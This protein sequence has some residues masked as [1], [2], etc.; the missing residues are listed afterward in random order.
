MKK[1]I[2]EIHCFDANGYYDMHFKRID[3]VMRSIGESKLLEKKW[4]RSTAI[5]GSWAL[6]LILKYE[7]TIPPLDVK[8]AMI[9]LEYLLKEDVADNEIFNGNTFFRIADIDVYDVSEKGS[10][11]RG[12][13]FRKGAKKRKLDKFEIF[14]TSRLDEIIRLGRDF[15]RERVSKDVLK[16]CKDIE[17]KIIN[18]CK[19]F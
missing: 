1:Y 2:V 16:S 11:K 14:A 9:G 10:S 6:S 17:Q 19:L 13:L 18:E 15:L 5:G 4:G 12:F 8:K 3:M 7:T